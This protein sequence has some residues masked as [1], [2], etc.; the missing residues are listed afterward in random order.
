MKENDVAYISKQFNL[1]K[2]IVEASVNDG[3][4]GQRIED[5]LKNKIIYSKDEF[6]K[7]KNNLSAE[8]QTKY[9]NELVEKANKGEIPND[10]H[11]PIKGAALQQ[12]E[13]DLSK[14]YE[15]TDYANIRDLISK[16]SE[17]H[18]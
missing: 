10:L 16:R 3:T 7:F 5:S 12:L 15:V 18:T 17:E 11:K 1:E 4:L 8:A 14:E 6:E 13:R 9:H 2:E